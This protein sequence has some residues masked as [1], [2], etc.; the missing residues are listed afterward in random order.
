MIRAGFVSNSS[1]SSFILRYKTNKMTTPK[2]VLDNLD[3]FEEIYVVGRDLCSGYDVF[4]LTYEMKRVIKNFPERWIKYAEI[5]YAVGDPIER[6]ALT[7]EESEHWQD[8]PI[9]EKDYRSIDSEYDT[10]YEFVKNYLL[11]P[12]EWEALNNAEWVEEDDEIRKFRAIQAF[13]YEEDLGCN[14][15]SDFTDTTMV[16]N[17]FI[18]SINEFIPLVFMSTPSDIREYTSQLRDDVRFYKGF[19]AVEFD[20]VLPPINHSF[21]IK[22]FFGIINETKDIKNF[23]KVDNWED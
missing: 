9:V 22:R 11:S 18:S 23:L 6:R 20:K 12:D 15:P 10:T 3:K 17:S 2:E 16:V 5:Q 8:F 19:K 21:Y 13:I 1:S 4:E 7:W 14:L